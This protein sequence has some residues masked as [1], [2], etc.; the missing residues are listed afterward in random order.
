MAYERAVVIG[1]G[2]VGR[3][4]SSALTAAGIPWTGVTRSAGWA[5]VNR[6]PQP[7]RVV[8]VRE[9][10]LAEVLSRLAGCDPASV[11]LVQ[12]GWIRPLLAGWDGCTRGLVWFTSKGEFFRTLRPSPF[13]GPVA[14][15]IAAALDRGGIPAETAADDAFRGLDAEK[16]GFNCV[17]GL[18]LAIHGMSLGEYLEARREEAEALFRESV[19]TCAEAL[20]VSAS[21]DW[22]GTFL[23]AVEPLGWLRAST[24]KALEFR[25]GAV[26]RLA[27]ELGRPVPVTARL[28]ATVG[29]PS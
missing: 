20:A 12:N 4:I 6:E 27:R 29:F 22:W 14:G 19:E 24:A 15:V 11:V 17:V 26:L 5:E 18:P 8:C 10:A 9:E 3:R 1:M 2:E 7:L 28:L 16:M 25:S 21:T 23:R 13:S